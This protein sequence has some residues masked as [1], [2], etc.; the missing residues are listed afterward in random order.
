M[1]TQSQV[2]LLNSAQDLLQIMGQMLAF[3]GCHQNP[4]IFNVKILSW[5]KIY[6]RSYSNPCFV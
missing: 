5:K 3:G 1:N 6:A 2:S 4:S